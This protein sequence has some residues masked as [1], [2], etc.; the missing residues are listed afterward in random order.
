MSDKKSRNK[1][2][3]NLN[4]PGDPNV[5]R[6]IISQVSIDYQCVTIKFLKVGLISICS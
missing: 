4:F 6:L 3:F 2:Y 1:I 5:K